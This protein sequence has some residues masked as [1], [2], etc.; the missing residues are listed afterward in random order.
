MILR[1]SLLI[2]GHGM[3]DAGL[4]GMRSRV[5][6]ASNDGQKDERNRQQ[7]ESPKP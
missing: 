2:R 6:I 1:A 4:V 7:N 3:I 5:M